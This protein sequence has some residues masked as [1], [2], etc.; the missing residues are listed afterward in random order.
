MKWNKKRH[1]KTPKNRTNLL[2]KICS[3]KEY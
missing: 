1:Q 2:K 3:H